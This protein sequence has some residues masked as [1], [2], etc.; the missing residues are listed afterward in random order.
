MI[1]SI[2]IKCHVVTALTSVVVALVFAVASPVACYSAAQPKVHLTSL[3]HG[4]RPLVPASPVPSEIGDFLNQINSYRTTNGAPG[5]ILNSAISD[6]TQ[7][8][9]DSQPDYAS[10][11][12]VP[13]SLLP[14]GYVSF[15]QVTGSAYNAASPPFPAE[16]ISRLTS[17]F[18]SDPARVLRD[19]DVSD[20]GLAFKRQGNNLY[21]YAVFARTQSNSYQ[22][23]Y[24]KYSWSPTIY[25]VQYD[26]A[27]WKWKQLNLADWTAVGSPSPRRAGWIAG[28]R[29]FTFAPSQNIYAQSPDG[30][31]H[32]LSYSEWKDSGF[33]QPTASAGDFVRYSW[34][35]SI[36]SVEYSLPTWT[37]KRLSYDDWVQLGQ[38]VPR[39][40]GFIPGTKYFKYATSAEIFTVAEDG[41]THKLSPSEWEA[42]GRPSPQQRFDGYLKNSWS[43]TI[44]YN[45]NLNI[46]NSRSVTY[47]EWAA[48]LFPNPQVS[49]QVPYSFFWKFAA[50]P[51]IYYR[52]PDG[53]DIRITPSEWSAAGWPWARPYATAPPSGSR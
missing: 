9:A 13:A 34:S 26:P 33:R 18:L 12:K 35:P 28:T 29:Y 23:D 52:S 8:W 46:E 10:A 15:S 42:A 7:T 50:K 11:Q 38:P 24:V 21:L 20:V 6:A 31:V 40:A 53:T 37:W 47:S 39:N 19:P 45:G 32:L 43:T 51:E 2:S 30:V 4:P 14:P 27:G 1:R 25:S 44:Y 16:L 22:T 48:S 49:S 3:G 36:Y 17:D 41:S 5:V